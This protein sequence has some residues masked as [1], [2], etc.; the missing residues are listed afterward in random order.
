MMWIFW[1]VVIALCSGYLGFRI[2]SQYVFDRAV[3]PCCQFMAASLSGRAAEDFVSSIMESDKGE[4]TA[5]LF[6]TFYKAGYFMG[7]DPEAMS[8]FVESIKHQDYVRLK[9]RKWAKKEVR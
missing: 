2:G 8:A 4:E 1:V 7:E 6:F 9:L 3:I 5:A